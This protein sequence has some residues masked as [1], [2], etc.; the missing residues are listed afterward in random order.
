MGDSLVSGSEYPGAPFDDEQRR[1]SEDDECVRTGCHER[2]GLIGVL[3]GAE[4]DRLPH[5]RND[6]GIDHQPDDLSGIAFLR[7]GDDGV[8][9]LDDD[10]QQQRGVDEADNDER[11]GD[12]PT[13]RALE[14]L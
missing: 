7:V 4:D 8:V 1:Q 9:D 6:A 13:G 12:T 14:D 2:G 3:S 5:H 10:E 11:I